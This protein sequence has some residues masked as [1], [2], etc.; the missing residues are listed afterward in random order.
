MASLLEVRVQ[1][2]KAIVLTYDRYR[3]L[4]DHMIHCYERLWPEHPFI[5][6]VP[7]QEKGPSLNSP[8]VQYHPSPSDIKGTVLTLLADLDDDEMVYW[9][10]D[11]KYPI[12]IHVKKLVQIHEWLLSTYQAQSIGGILFCRCRGSLIKENLTDRRISDNNGNTFLERNSY[13]Q[14]W[15]HQYVKVRVIRHIRS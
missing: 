7:Y 13:K 10:I 11:D 15:L 4:T 14:I 8:R 2:V 5:F 6:Q 12:R 3:S 9:C 1:P